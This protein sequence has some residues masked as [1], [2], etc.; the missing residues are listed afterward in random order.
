MSTIQHLGDPPN[1][2]GARRCAITQWQ[3][4]RSGTASAWIRF[5]CGG[6]ATKIST[7][8]SPVAVRTDSVLPEKS[9]MP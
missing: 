9:D 7:S 3:V 1:R 5:E 2:P 6:T 8:A 4:F